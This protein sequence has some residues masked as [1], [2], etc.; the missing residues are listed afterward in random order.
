V[1]V[2]ITLEEFNTR[3]FEK[4]EELVLLD[5]MVLD[6]SKYMFNHPGGKFL[7][8]HCIGRD[9]GKFFYGGYILENY[10][11]SKP[12]NHSFIAKNIA[13]NLLVARLQ[14]VAPDNYYKAHICKQSL[15]NSTTSTFTFKLEEKVTGV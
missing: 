10:K 13:K 4:G 9:I 14:K 15:I 5:D 3:V 6:I 7:L 12:L 1:E 11:F 8:A 2:T